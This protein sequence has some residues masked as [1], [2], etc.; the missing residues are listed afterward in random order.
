MITAIP[1]RTFLLK[2]E[3]TSFGKR[4]DVL[5]K[6]GEKVNLSERDAIRFWGALKFNEKDQKM[7]LEF[8]KKNKVKRDV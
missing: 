2:Q 6:R 7:L 5:A 1:K 3:E 8:S 4:K